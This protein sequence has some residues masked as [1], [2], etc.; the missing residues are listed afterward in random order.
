MNNLLLTD[1]NSTNTVILL[2]TFYRC[3]L[4][5]LHSN[6]TFNLSKLETIVPNIQ[7]KGRGGP[8][9]KFWNFG[10]EKIVFGM[11]FVDSK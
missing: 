11:N 7:R 10:T 1:T 6:K 8:W 9:T 5:E 4:V 2:L 3:K